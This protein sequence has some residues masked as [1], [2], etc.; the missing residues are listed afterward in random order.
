MADEHPLFP[1]KSTRRNREL[2][3][4]I[5]RIRQVERVKR[6]CCLL[7]V[8]QLRHT[9]DPL[10]TVAGEVGF[11]LLAFALVVVLACWKM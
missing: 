9:D 11:N 2:V 8:V 10:V 4:A 6:C 5:S 7:L 3:L 1:G